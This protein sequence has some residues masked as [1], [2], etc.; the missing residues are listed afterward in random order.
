MEDEKH[1]LNARGAGWERGEL[2]GE[3]EAALAQY[4]AIE[5]RDGLEQRVLAN[6]RGERES[7]R[8]GWT[9]GWLPVAVG[10]LAAAVVV[11]G[12]GTVSWKRPD[13]GAIAVSPPRPPQIR[14]LPHEEID[15]DYPAFAM[16]KSGVGGKSTV[17]GKESRSHRATE[18]T[19]ILAA[20]PKLEQFPSP[21]PLSEQERILASYVERYPETAELV[22]KARAAASLQD[23]LEEAAEASKQ[24]SE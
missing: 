23:S 18:H 5:P 16:E 9:S 2:S 19:A 13:S 12:A 6:L 4:A 8:R 10:A 21:R 3:L 17:S 7:A 20:Q 1:D 11:A 22:A 15:T 14:A 24:S